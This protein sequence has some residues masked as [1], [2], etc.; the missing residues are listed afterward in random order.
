M[1]IDKLYSNIYKAFLL[2]AITLFVTSY[3][4]TGASRFNANIV[5]Y[6]I[7]TISFLMMSLVV[8]NNFL[9]YNSLVN[10]KT[11][12]QLFSM[13]GPI[14]LLV[15]SVGFMMYLMINNKSAIMKNRVS[16]SYYT[17]SNIGLIFIGLQTYI[18]YQ[19]IDTP[20]FK[21]SGK[22]PSVPLGF[23]YLLGVFAVICIINMYI[24]LKYFK[25]EGFDNSNLYD[26]NNPYN[27]TIFHILHLQKK[28]KSHEIIV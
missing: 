23:I 10:I 6:F 17:F 7:L 18:F 4:T 20:M 11:F 26:Y 28:A 9:N 21:I 25:T 2:V 13:L 3:A 16:N 22:I 5:A 19:N 15:F 24:I 1:E 8:I 12:L 27:E 14:I